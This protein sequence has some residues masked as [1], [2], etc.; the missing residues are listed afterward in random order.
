MPEVHDELQADLRDRIALV[1][2]SA[3]SLV[4]I[5]REPLAEVA[6]GVSHETTELPE[7]D[8]DTLDRVHAAMPLREG[9]HWNALGRLIGADEDRG[10]EFLRLAN[11]L[12]ALYPLGSQGI[13]PFW[14]SCCWRFQDDL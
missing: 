8:D 1:A 2:R 13:R 6:T 14:T 11:A 4:P 9:G 10:P 5:L 7:P 12:S 3:A